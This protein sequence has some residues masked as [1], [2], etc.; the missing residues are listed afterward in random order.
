MSHT[1][2]IKS[3]PIRSVTALQAAVRELQQA[4]VQCSLAQ[5]QKPRMYYENQHGECDYVLKLDKSRYDIG[6]QKQKDGT[7]EMV[8]DTWNNEI[9]QQVGTKAVNWAERY[10]SSESKEARELRNNPQAHVG[11]LMQLY[12]KHAAIQT[13]TS[14][15]YMVT[16]CSVGQDMK[17]HLTIGVP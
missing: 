16:G 11:S 17:V 5:N 4:G 2:T 8:L 14:K 10:S 12:T 6:F 15:G 13:A 9:A 1:T 3:V 7:Y